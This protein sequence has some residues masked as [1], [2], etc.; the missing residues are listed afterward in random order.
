MK[1]LLALIATASIVLPVLNATSIR[2]SRE[3]ASEA[4]TLEPF[5]SI[6]VTNAADVTIEQ[7]D[8]QSL[9]IRTDTNILPLIST[10]VEHGCLV[11]SDLEKNLKPSELTVEIIVPELEA[12]DITG[13]S[14]VRGRG[15]LTGDSFK[16]SVSGS[17]DVDLRL[18]VGKLQTRV[19]G[20]CDL[21][22]NGKAKTQVIQISGSGDVSASD[23]ATVST[24]LEISGHGD[25]VVAA[26]DKLNIEISG[27][28]QVRYRGQP[29]VTKSIT[30]LGDVARTED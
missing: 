23:L 8:A 18:D 1:L 15:V 13:V 2:G 24:D 10:K 20:A 16:I 11:I 5:R 4:R 12:I 26:S 21:D 29:E 3:L 28:G 14:D 9:T 22:L 17:A 19:T 6:R 25:C 27:V 7:G 30:G